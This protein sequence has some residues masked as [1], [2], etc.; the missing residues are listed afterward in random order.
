MGF[1]DGFGHQQVGGYLSAY[2][3]GVVDEHGVGVGEHGGSE[4]ADHLLGEA[5]DG[6]DG[7]RVEF[8]DGGANPLESDLAVL[9]PDLGQQHIIGL[10]RRLE[11][12]FE[13]DET[14]PDPIL[15]LGGRR[16]GERDDE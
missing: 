10:G 3:L 2:R 9:A 6:R 13:F 14:G 8:G 7:R 16:P 5:M 15:Q 12:G 1:A 4:G 11:H